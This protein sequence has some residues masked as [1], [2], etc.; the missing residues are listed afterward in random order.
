MDTLIESGEILLRVK[1]I[2]DLKTYNKVTK[3]LKSLS[4]VT[5]VQAQQVNADD[6][7]FALSSRSG[8]LG[9]AQ[10]IALGHVLVAEISKPI[11]RDQAVENKP[12]QLKVELTYKRVP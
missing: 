3:Y 5:Q 1:N 4:I 8:R 9:I 11:I 10:A 12:E 2:S 7:V 6:V